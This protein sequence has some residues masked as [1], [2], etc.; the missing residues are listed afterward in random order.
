MTT[1]T[2][3]F[4]GKEYTCRWVE[5]NED[6]DVLVGPMSLLDD[7]ARRKRSREAQD[8]DERICFYIDDA[9]LKEDDGTL[10]RELSK[11]CEIFK[12]IRL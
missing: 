8:T 11:Q 7:L 6:N 5:D 9:F 3:L 2:I 1:E 12:P 10:M 4:D